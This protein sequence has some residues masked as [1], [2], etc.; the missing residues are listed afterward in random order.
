MGIDLASRDAGGAEN[1]D[2]ADVSKDSGTATI[3]NEDG[4]C[5]TYTAIR[6]EGECQKFGTQSS[7]G[8]LSSTDDR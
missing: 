3:M 8:L 5:W 2:A 4:I 1:L 7:P 6:L